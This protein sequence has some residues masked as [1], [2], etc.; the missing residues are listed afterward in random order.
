[1]ACPRAWSREDSA[2]GRAAEKQIRICLGGA[3][4]F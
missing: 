2:L 4:D 1:M 3:E